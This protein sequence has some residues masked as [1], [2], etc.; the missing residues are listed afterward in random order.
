MEIEGAIQGLEALI[1]LGLHEGPEL[2]E[3]VS[4]SRYVLGIASGGY[5]PTKN[6]ELVGRLKWLAVHAGVRFRWV[7]GHQGE[8]HNETCDRLAKQGKYENTPPE[9]LAKAAKK[10]KRKKNNA[11]TPK[12]PAKAPG[13]VLGDAPKT[14]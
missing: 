11:E 3:L 12:P 2:C 4:D 6:L 13:S 14:S 9:L 7:R 10:K 8:V 1:K 5:V